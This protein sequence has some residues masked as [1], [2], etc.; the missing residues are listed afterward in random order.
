MDFGD[1]SFFQS[2]GSVTPQLPEPD[3]VRQVAPHTTIVRFAELNL[4]VKRG[5][6]DRV[7]WEEALAMRTIG[8]AFSSN[9]V[10]VPEVFG[11]RVDADEC[12]LY[13]S[14]VQGSTLRD[15][16]PSLLQMDKESISGQLSKIVAHMRLLRQDSHP[17][18]IGVFPHDN[19]FSP[20][21][22]LN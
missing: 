3:V 22:M 4:V 18:F 16:W 11:W 13:M 14:L 15:A 19:I 2:S 7:T 5:L 8:L 6:A 1:T 17:P 20:D 9:E 21:S 10:P 12:F